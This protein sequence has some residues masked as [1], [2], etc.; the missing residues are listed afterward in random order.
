MQWF[1][2]RFNDLPGEED[3]VKSL[4]RIAM[5]LCDYVLFLQGDRNKEN[6]SIKQLTLFQKTTGLTPE[7]ETKKKKKEA[8]HN[9]PARQLHSTRISAVVEKLK[10]ILRDNPQA[11]CLVFSEWMVPLKLVHKA[12]AAGSVPSLLVTSNLQGSTSVKKIAD[13]S[14]SRSDAQILLLPL[15]TGGEGLNLT[16]ANH[17]LFVEMPMNISAAKQVFTSLNRRSYS[18]RCTPCL[19]DWSLPP[20]GPDTNHS[21]LHTCCQ[22]H[23]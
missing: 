15:L 9:T 4:K 1:S 18:L 21:C 2:L 8:W 14:E 23:A 20:H 7:T 10:S 3:R 13:F 6:T 17:V 22:R 11:R 12:L 5:Q 16:A 19:G